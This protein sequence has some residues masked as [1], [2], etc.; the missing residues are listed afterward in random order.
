MKI[1]LSDADRE[2]IGGPEW[3]DCSL[4]LLPVREAEAIEDATGIEP[5][6][7]IKL[8]IPAREPH[9]T[10]PALIR[11]RYT[12]RGMRL[13]VWLGLHRAGVEVSFDELDFDY[14]QFAG[15]RTA[16]VEPEGKDDGSPSDEPSTP[17][18]SAPSGRR[19]RSKTSPK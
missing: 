4:D 10:D 16:Q 11:Y 19:T 1:R 2:R 9:P 15:W 13:R 14:S 12:P 6:E 5:L 18:K 7:A 17:S 8:M 3:L